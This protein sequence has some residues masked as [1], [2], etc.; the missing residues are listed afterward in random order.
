MSSARWVCVIYSD[1]S[2]PLGIPRKRG[3][4]GVGGRNMRPPGS[5]ADCVGSS[6]NREISR[7]TSETDPCPPRGGFGPFTRISRGLSE[8][9]ENGAY[10]ARRGGICDPPDPRPTDCVGSSGNREISR[11]ISETDPCPPRG[12][13][14]PFT[15]ISRDLSEFGENGAYAARRGGIC[16]PA[17]PRPIA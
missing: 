4:R 3:L 16:D 10:M 15:R 11:R 14:G 2:G 6:G 1:F 12:G 13:F 5:A 8:F 9:G 17:D 7:R